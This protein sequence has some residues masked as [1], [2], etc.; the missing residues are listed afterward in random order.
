MQYK[1]ICVVTGPRVDL[2]VTLIDRLKA[3]V[4]ERTGIVWNTKETVFL[5]NHCIIEVYPSHHIDS[6]R[7]LTDVKLIL[8]DEGDF[9]PPGEQENARI[10]SERYIGKS[11]PYI[12]MVS[13]PNL[14][15]GLFEK[16]ELE[17]DKTCIYHRLHLPYTVGLGRIYTQ[18]DIAEARKI[19]IISEENI[20][21]P[22][23]MA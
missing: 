20:I 23:G 9:F 22:T 8:I 18:Q 12:I 4:S 3:I 19:P 14:P 17:D 13:T 2:A 7:G 16:I 11:D 6:M 10:V 15:G 1:R 21:W 5:L